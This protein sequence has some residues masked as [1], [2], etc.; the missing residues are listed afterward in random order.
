MEKLKMELLPEQQTELQQIKQHFN[1]LLL[2]TMSNTL[3][4]NL[5]EI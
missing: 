1:Q 2:N 5:L 4:F 3:P